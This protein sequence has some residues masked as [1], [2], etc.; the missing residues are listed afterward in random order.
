[1]VR[2]LARRAVVFAASTK[3][4]LVE[5]VDDLSTVRMKREVDAGRWA[6]GFV[7]EELV[8][9]EVRRPLAQDVRK[10][11]RCEHRT[12]EALADCRGGRAPITT[13]GDAIST[14]HGSSA[15]TVTQSA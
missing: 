10:P 5:R 3:R 8:G 7:D 1:M 14:T 12:V 13:S 6:V 4:R 15:E 2:P 9:L 11:N